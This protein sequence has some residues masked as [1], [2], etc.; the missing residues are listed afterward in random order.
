MG[1]DIV[2]FSVA[3]GVVGIGVMKTQRGHCN[4]EIAA[5]NPPRSG[6]CLREWLSLHKRGNDRR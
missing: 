2:S 4:R 1:E 5:L 6:H 3:I